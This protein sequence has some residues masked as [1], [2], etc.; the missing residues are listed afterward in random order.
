[1]HILILG[2]YC[3]CNLGDSVICQ[4]VAEQLREWFPEARITIR[5]MIVRDRLAP[6]TM[7]QE[8]MLRRRQLFTQAKRKLASLG[9]DRILPREETRVAANL[10][11]LDEI[12]AG[13]YSLAIFAGGQLFMDGYALFLEAC[14]ERLG[15]RGIPVIFNA[16]G[17]GPC[18]SRAIRKRLRRTLLGGN[19]LA[20]SCRDGASRMEA[21][22]GTACAVETADPALEAGRLLK[23][24]K[25]PSDTVGLGV[26][27]PNAV[28]YGRSLALWQRI[29][30]ELERRGEKW[31]LFTNGD[32]A[33]EVFARRLCASMPE[34]A[35]RSD[36]IAPRCVTPEELVQTVAGYKGII[37][38]RLHSQ[39]IAV[40]LDIPT[41]A[42]VWDDK[43]PV[44]FSKIGR[45]ERCFPVKSGAEAVVDGLWAAA[46]EGYD[47]ERIDAQAA[48]QRKWLLDQVKRGCGL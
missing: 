20:I 39:I 12:C 18:H 5:D 46:R 43:L 26:M 23:I 32:P 19:V 21:L 36:L 13:D 16:C 3:S 10:A 33:D 4:C 40:S 7:P 17:L 27:Y 37:S 41:A 45:P 38:Y 2:A 29:I 8:T 31:Q 14:V 1:M 35:G 25:Q 30:R 11:H 47:R 28:P 15:R 24:R 34:L 22:L 48:I 44:F 42:L 6:K 9:V